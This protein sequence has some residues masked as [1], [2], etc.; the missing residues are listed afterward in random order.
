MIRRWW[1][2]GVLALALGVVV[3]GLVGQLS[4]RGSPG[5]FV[6]GDSITVMASGPD[7][8]PGGWEVD[9]VSGRTTPEGIAVAQAADLAGRSAVI[10]ALGSNDHSD[11]AAAFGV[12]ID[13]MIEAIGP[14]PTVIWVNVD[15]QTSTLANAGP[16]VN[17]ALTAATARHVNLRVA[18]WNQY[19][20]TL[21]GTPGLRAGDGV[22]YDSKGSS[23]RRAWMLGLLG[24]G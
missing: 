10:V 11:S 13:Q 2:V 20:Q 7:P 19:V 9:A 1:V 14:G 23:L 5:I 17:A 4:D 22:H 3:A 16:G 6:I 18:D 12:K 15:A 21:A 24:P 8:W